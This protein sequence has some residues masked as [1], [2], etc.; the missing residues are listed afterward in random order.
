MCQHLGDKALGAKQSSSPVLI[1][2][3][4]VLQ[5]LGRSYTAEKVSTKAGMSA[6]VPEGRK[7][8]SGQSRWRNPTKTSTLGRADAVSSPGEKWCKT[9]CP[10]IFVW[11]HLFCQNFPY[12]RRN[13]IIDFFVVSFSVFFVWNVR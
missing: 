12:I 10:V 7:V 3:S 13:R 5:V 4:A 9:L 2:T 1:C 11:I 8:A 6:L